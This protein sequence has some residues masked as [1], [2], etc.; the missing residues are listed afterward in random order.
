MRSCRNALLSVTALG[1]LAYALGSAQVAQADGSHGRWERPWGAEFAAG[2]S[3]SGGR[4]GASGLAALR[5]AHSLS[6]E[7][8]ADYAA[9]RSA[10]TA[11]LGLR[12]LFPALWLLDRQTGNAWLDHSLESLALFLG[13]AVPL[14]RHGREAHLQLGAGFRLPLRLWGLGL[15]CDYRRRWVRG[16]GHALPA[17]WLQAALSW[18]TH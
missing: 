10:L 14:R 12:P 4:V 15:R 6:L 17:H 16:E 13:S 11:E 9:R 1:A 7:V 18:Q 5:Y 2:S 8:G 3:L